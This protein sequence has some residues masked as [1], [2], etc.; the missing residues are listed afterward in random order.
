M[1][2]RFGID[3][4]GAKGTFFWK[5]P[6]IGRRM[7]IRHAATAV[8]GY[9]LLPT[10]PGDGIARAAAATKGTARNCIFILLSGAPSHSDTFDLKEGPWTPAFFNPTSYGDLRFPQGLMPNLAAQIDSLAFVRSARSWAA[11][12]GLSQTW[13]QI[14]RNPTSAAGKISPHIGS[15]A[16]IELRPQETDPLL[17]T[18]LS[19][20][21][22]GGHPENGYFPPLYAPFYV[23]PRG[24]GLGNTQHRDGRARFE[25]RSNLLAEIDSERRADLA[26]GSALAEMATWNAAARKMMYN[27]DIDRIFTFAADERARFGSS[28]F[29]DACI[30]ARNLLRARAGTRFIQITFGGWDNHSNIYQQNAALGGLSRQF[31]NGLS[32]LM[33]DLR[34][35]GLLDQTLIVAM[36]EFGRTVG[37]LNASSGR[38][39]HLQQSVLFAGA[40]I[41]GGRAIGATDERGFATAEPGW[42][43]GRDVRPEDIEATIYSALGIDWTTTRYDDPLGR[44]FE[45]VPSNNDYGFGPVHEL[46]E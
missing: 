3:W 28:N 41:H 11:V 34:A 12:H 16:S 38:D 37:P 44:G 24:A 42:S 31:D 45:Y 13:V 26:Y 6:Q 33:S 5:R 36:G 10:R 29:G 39:H 18:F 15:I 22:G 35:D 40:G 23:S 4:T 25:T 43:G 21:A 8:G 19:L 30:T 27:A 2:D 14:G 9:F 1:K 17:P 7:F 20:N 32:T 46:W